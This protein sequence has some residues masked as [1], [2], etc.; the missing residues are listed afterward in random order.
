MRL[1]RLTRRRV[2]R[3][4]AVGSTAFAMA[5]LAK[6]FI[7]GAAAGG[8]LR[9]GL[10][11]HWVPGGNEPWKRLAGEWGDKNKVDVR[12][13]FITS[14]G[15]KLN[16]TIA[17]E[18]Q[19][20]AGHDILHLSDA[21]PGAYASRLEPVG[22]IASGLVE[23]FGKPLEG[24]RYGAFRDGTWTAVPIS[25]GTMTLPCCGRIDLLKE[26][27]GLDIQKMYPASAPPDS[28]LAEEW[29]WDNF[30]RAAEALNKA[31]HPFGLPLST[32]SDASNFATT[33]FASHGAYLVDENG[34]TTVNSD[35]VRQVLD[36]FK[37]LV[38]HLPESVFAWDNAQNNK[39]LVSGQGSLIMNPPSAWAV[40]MRDRPEIGSQLWHFPPPTGP[41]GRFMGTN[42]GYLGVWRFSPN[43]AAA[44]DFV[45]YVTTEAAFHEMVEAS[46]G[47]DIPPYERLHDFEIWKKQGPPPGVNYN[48]PPRGEVTSIMI[49]YPAPPG[50]AKTLFAQG[51]ICKLIARYAKQ[52]MSMSEAIAQTAEEI[53]GYKRV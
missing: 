11:D 49:G 45:R 4:A 22:D 39:F 25:Q 14:Q 40:A 17:T 28:E 46:K 27:A 5:T 32:W 38:P 10:W 47:Y 18:A 43:K 21:Q 13:D 37:R 26:H 23:R 31:G 50:L 1:E 29:T 2:L 16:L 30:L 8:T 15:D 9:V 6:P 20:G 44:K 34:D 48:Y 36:W 35:A 51:T 42:Y 53:E 7:H 33:V 52:G 24:A 41:A 12:L 19:A 3:T